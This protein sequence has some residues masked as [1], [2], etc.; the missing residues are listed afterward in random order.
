MTIKAHAKVN[1][2]LSVGAPFPERHP[3]A[4]MHP[5][6]SW[7]HAIDLCDT[8][9]LARAGPASFDLAWDTGEPIGWDPA[10]DL[11][12]RAHKAVEQAVG[13]E[14]PTRVRV[15]KSIPAGGGL[16]GGSSDA[17]AALL[18]LRALH[19]LDL[20]DDRLI[21]LGA[22]LGSD[23]PFFIDAES[24]DRALPP[25]PA[26]VTGLGERVERVARR[27]APITL[28]V[29]PFGCS[30]GAVYRAFDADARG[31]CDEDRV[32]KAAGGALDPASWFNDLER[33][34][35]T[36]RP[37]LGGLVAALRSSLAAP[38]QVTGSG[39]TVVAACAPDAV[40]PLVPSP[41]YRVLGA[42]LV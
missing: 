8:I 1:L 16:G 31:P 15:R 14:L 28:V 42:R 3:R 20:D 24:F 29:P 22:A 40:R 30:T 19:G 21:A 27:N 11:V 38:V 33:P 23:I 5:V 39:S 2:A 12:V 17:A 10:T 37:E 13:R 41:G 7:M 35:C 6:A 36:V 4:G 25:R 32:R 26:V 34:A 18:G 9:E